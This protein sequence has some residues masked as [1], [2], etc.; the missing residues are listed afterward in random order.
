MEL[1]HIVTIVMIWM[2]HCNAKGE[3]GEQRCQ[4]TCARCF[5]NRQDSLQRMGCMEKCIVDGLDQFTCPGSQSFLSAV[6]KPSPKLQ[7]EIE[8]HYAKKTEL[9]SNGDIETLMTMYTDDLVCIV[10]N[11]KPYIG[12]DGMMKFS[13]AL[14]TANPDIVHVH[15][16]P[17]A[18]GDEYGIIWIN[19]I[20][21]WLDNQ[22][23]PVSKNRMMAV[24]KRVEGKL[25]EHVLVLFQ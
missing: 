12:K 13:T 16:D 15:F 3:F 7:S 2:V 4:G 14:I 22:D 6:T 10:D 8:D 19:G 25:Q 11:Q 5:A 24:L 9:F 20:I 23:Q 21:T 18:F 17:V 1:H